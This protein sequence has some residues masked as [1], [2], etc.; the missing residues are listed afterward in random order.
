MSKEKEDSTPTYSYG[1]K[2]GLEGIAEDVIEL[3]SV[4]VI[5][6]TGLIGLF[7]KK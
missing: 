5:I 6:L 2:D 3:V 1:E 7:R 4:V